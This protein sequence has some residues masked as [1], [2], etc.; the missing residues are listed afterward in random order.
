MGRRPVLTSAPFHRIEFLLDLEVVPNGLL[1]QI[2]V[3]WRVGVV[4]FPLIFYP[5][6]LAQYAGVKLSLKVSQPVSQ[7][8]T[9]PDA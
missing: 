2:A 3:A 8:V 5:A 7:P 6:V 1:I 9:S 4:R